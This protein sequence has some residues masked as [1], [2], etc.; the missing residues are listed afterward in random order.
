MAYPRT[1]VIYFSSEKPV[2]IEAYTDKHE[3]GNSIG[4]VLSTEAPIIFH[5]EIGDAIRYPY[6]GFK[7]KSPNIINLNKYNEIHL[8]IQASLSRRIRIGLIIDDYKLKNGRTVPINLTAKLKYKEGISE[9]II[10]LQAFEIPNWWFLNHRIDNTELTDIDLSRVSSI[11]IQTD[12][13][14]KAGTSDVITLNMLEIKNNPNGILIIISIIILIAMLLVLIVFL[15]RTKYRIQLVPVPYTGQK[16]EGLAETEIDKIQR[17]IAENYHLPITTQLIQHE[18]GISKSKIPSL[19]KQ[20]LNTTLKKLLITIRLNE[21]KRL[22]IE[23]DLPINEIADQVGFGH[24]S[25]FNRVYKSAE[26]KTPNESRASG[27]ESKN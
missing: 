10:P 21:A 22:L 12:Q 7:I 16:V 14:L 4:K 8:S 20:E 25:H 1:K 24:V 15:F 18:T 2:E 23:S 13:L 11:D 6:A 26:G 9:Y 27:E 17:F 5:S 3:G 19:L